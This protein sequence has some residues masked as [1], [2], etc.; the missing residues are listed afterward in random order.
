MGDM[1]RSDSDLVADFVSLKGGPCQNDFTQIY[2]D[3][4]FWLFG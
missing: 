2:I 1:R 4:D 3:D